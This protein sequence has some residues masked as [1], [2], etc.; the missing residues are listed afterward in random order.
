MGAVTWFIIQELGFLVVYMQQFYYISVE[1][2]YI[3]E[4]QGK[5]SNNAFSWKTFRALQKPKLEKGE[6]VKRVHP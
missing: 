4:K 2:V 6:R 5:V 1:T 3:L